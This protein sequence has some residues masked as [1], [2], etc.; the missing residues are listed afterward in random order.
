MQFFFVSLV[1][2]FFV[3][4]CALCSSSL[5]PFVALCFV[6]LIVVFIDVVVVVV[7]SGFFFD[8]DDTRR[9]RCNKDMSYKITRVIT[10][11]IAFGFF[12]LFLN[13]NSGN[14]KNQHKG[15]HDAPIA[16]AVSNKIVEYIQ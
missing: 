13:N 9:R 1:S 7:G 8:D 6:V 12:R 10:T 11:K 5:L 14:N 16:A 4:V 15:F 3:F 2:H